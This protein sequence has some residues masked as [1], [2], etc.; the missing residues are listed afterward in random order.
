MSDSRAILERLFQAGRIPIQRAPLFDTEPSR[1]PGS[2][3]GC[4]WART[5]SSL[6]IN[7]AICE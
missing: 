7:R 6:P 4:A 2:F 3:G 1:L 5:I